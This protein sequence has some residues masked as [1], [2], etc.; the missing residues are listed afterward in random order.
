MWALGVVEAAGLEPH[1]AHA[2]EVK[3]TNRGRISDRRQRRRGFGNAAAQRHTAGSLDRV[4]ERT[5]SAAASTQRLAIRRYQSAFKSR[6]QGVVGQPR[7]P[8][9]GVLCGT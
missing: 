8:A 9:S 7:G 2:L 3:K 5:R 6:I 1:L 4:A